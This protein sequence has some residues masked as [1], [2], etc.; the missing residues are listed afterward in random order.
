MAFMEAQ[1]D[2]IK[3]LLKENPVVQAGGWA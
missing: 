1:R 3:V 2:A